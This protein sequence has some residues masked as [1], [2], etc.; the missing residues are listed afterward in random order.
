MMELGHATLRLQSKYHA[1]HFER[2]TH[3]WRFVF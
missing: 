2:L 1:W 3:V